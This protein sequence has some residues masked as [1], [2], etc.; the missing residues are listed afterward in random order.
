MNGSEQVSVTSYVLT[1]NATQ[2]D[3][4]P[5]RQP[6]NPYYFNQTPARIGIQQCPEVVAHS[7][8]KALVSA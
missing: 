7:L 2:T 1:L 8:K 6:R 5:D 4:Q 3:Y